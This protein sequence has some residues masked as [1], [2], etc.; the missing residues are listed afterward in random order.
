MKNEGD[1]T[2]HVHSTLYS[3]VLVFILLIFG[4]LDRTVLLSLFLK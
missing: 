3:T 4:E 2:I 1:T